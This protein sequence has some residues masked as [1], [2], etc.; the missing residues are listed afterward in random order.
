MTDERRLNEL[1]A[2]KMMN[3]H[4]IGCYINPD[5]AAALIPYDEDLLF[6]NNRRAMTKDDAFRQLITL[7]DWM[8]LGRTNSKD[9]KYQINLQKEKEP[10]KRLDTI[11]IG[12]TIYSTYYVLQFVNKYQRKTDEIT[13]Y[14]FDKDGQ[15]DIN[16]PIILTTD[17]KEWFYFIAP[18]VL[19]PMPTNVWCSYP[20]V[21]TLKEH[22]REH[23][24]IKTFNP[25]TGEME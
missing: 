22:V 8:E 18:R 6:H 15:Q 1:K 5:H 13:F 16:K 24:N 3:E 7:Y 19:D 10:T 17:D 2:L 9:F 25:I 12:N 21:K 11:M 20:R 23:Y 14:V 4:G